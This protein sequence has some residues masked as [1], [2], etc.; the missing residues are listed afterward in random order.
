MRHLVA[1]FYLCLLAFSV[2]VVRANESLEIAPAY[3]EIVLA[4]DVP[5]I[6]AEF[7]VTNKTSQPVTLELLPTSI[8]QENLSGKISYELF[9][10]A[11]NQTLPYLTFSVDRFV[12]EPQATREIT[13]TIINHSKL[14]P[15]GTY[16]AIVV[17]NVTE[18]VIGKQLIQPAL[19]TLLLISK[20]GGEQYN[21]SLTDVTGLPKLVAFQL[22]E[23]IQL[24]FRNNGNIHVQPRGTVAMMG[25]LDNLV[26]QGTINQ[27]SL[28]ILPGRERILLQPIQKAAH[29]FPV[30]LVTV[31]I[32]G[33]AGEERTP[34]IYQTSFLYLNPLFIG[35]LLAAALVISTLLILMKKRKWQRAGNIPEKKAGNLPEKHP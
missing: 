5:R 17:R 23:S 34:F 14:N 33:S 32:S 15:G 12:L 7:A 3:Q 35:V 20:L 29:I 4:E 26:A 8:D 16:L 6:I 28:Y 25:L 10:G 30:D 24:K 22:P 11:A 18:R 9:S 1:G 19:A 31:N 2:T 13:A 27:A 21:L